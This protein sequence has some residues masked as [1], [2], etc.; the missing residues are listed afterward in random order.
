MTTTHLNTNIYVEKRL[1]RQYE[2]A[3]R[4]TFK[5]EITDAIF[6]SLSFCFSVGIMSAYYF[7]ND[8]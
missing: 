5:W 1:K 7:E 8:N 3:D 2:A 4:A 6:S